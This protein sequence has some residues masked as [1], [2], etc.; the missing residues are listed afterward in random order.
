MVMWG[1][2]KKECL[3]WRILWVSREMAWILERPFGAAPDA[4]KIHSD[5]KRKKNS[6]GVKSQ[7]WLQK[8]R[9][10]MV[11]KESLSG[12]NSKVEKEEGWVQR[13]LERVSKKKVKEVRD[14]CKLAKMGWESFSNPWKRRE[15]QP[16]WQQSKSRWL[17][18]DKSQKEV[19]KK[20]FLNQKHGYTEQ[21]K[22]E[23]PAYQWHRLRLS[24]WY[25]PL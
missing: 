12:R 20:V 5:S 6:D 13:D 16:N 17:R 24:E 2:C 14:E 1:G 22:V 25:L 9:W 7:S 3:C 4:Q 19:K 15:N 10:W 21:R 11:V 18:S 23:N 8:S